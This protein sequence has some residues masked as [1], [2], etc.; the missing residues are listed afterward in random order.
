MTVFTARP[1]LI[2]SSAHAQ[3]EEQ[4]ATNE[5]SVPHYAAF[6]AHRA[7]VT[8]LA[9]AAAPSQPAPRLCV[10]GA[11]NCYDLDLPVLSQAYS[12]IHLVDIDAPALARA[13]QAQDAATRTH[14][15]HHAPIDLTG[16]IERL[17][18]WKRMEVTPAELMA[19][20]G[21][22]SKSIASNLPR[23]F[24]VVISACV[25][26]QLHLL[27]L[28]VLSDRHR[29][30]EPLRQFLNLVHLR[31]IALLLE[32]S[33]RGL[34]INDVVSDEMLDAQGLDPNLQ[35]LDLLRELGRRGSLIHAVHPEFL[36]WSV[37]ED[38][39]LS[40]KVTLSAP[41]HAWRWDVGPD[42]SFLVCAQELVPG[43][44][45]TETLQ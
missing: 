25:L 40:H 12:E 35:P 14:L 45:R 28:N 3:V 24:D 23:P 4:K 33:G 18:A 30:Y 44:G 13:C 21:A 15:H 43:P 11:G 1:A 5:S 2:T 38:P 10:L 27:L 26:T 39:F 7:R 9:L 8:E 42:R 37:R 29:L 6:A 41:T 32:P 34:L 16:A 20:P 17:D 19:W 31:T 22:A 36:A